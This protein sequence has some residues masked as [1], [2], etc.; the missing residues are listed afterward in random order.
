[1]QPRDAPAPLRVWHGYKAFLRERD[2]ES[3]ERRR[4]TETERERE[5]EREREKSTLER[6]NSSN[7]PKVGVPGGRQALERLYLLGSVYM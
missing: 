1:M 5:R 6:E 2:G 4:E 3:R 7:T